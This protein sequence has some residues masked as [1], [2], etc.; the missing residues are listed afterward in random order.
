MLV[1][2]VQSSSRRSSPVR[3]MT[4][5]R[6]A[7]LP[8]IKT[9]ITTSS[10]RTASERKQGT[11]PESQLCGFCQSLSGGCHCFIR[12]PDRWH[13]HVTGP[14][15]KML[16]TLSTLLFSSSHFWLVSLFGF[17]FSNRIETSQRTSIE[18]HM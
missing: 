6:Q 4:I 5:L 16:C 12:A 18:T 17:L 3:G 2:I 14:G 9:E 8:L 10:G 13:R 15:I 7:A 1:A 11:R